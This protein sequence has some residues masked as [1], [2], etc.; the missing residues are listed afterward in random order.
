MY[1]LTI[2]HLSTSYLLLEIMKSIETEIRQTILEPKRKILIDGL[3][4]VI[5]GAEQAYISE[6]PNPEYYEIWFYHSFDFSYIIIGKENF[7]IKTRAAK[8]YELLTSI[9]KHHNL[10]IE[11]E[12]EKIDELK[13]K[14]EFDFFSDCWAEIEN[15]LERKIRCFLVE[16]GIIRGWDVNKRELVDGEKIE[17]ILN[18][19][20]IP[21]HY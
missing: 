7:V 21:N 1:N 8:D 9:L 14:T 15:T 20:G 12:E 5:S 3:I 13:Q 4:S 19:E 17:D 18:E 10:S 11:S 2:F 16:H 6:T